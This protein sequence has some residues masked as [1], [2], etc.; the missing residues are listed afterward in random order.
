MKKLAQRRVPKMFFDYADSGDWTES[1]YAAN[2]S[3]FSQIKLRQRVMVDMTNRTLETKM[4]GKKVSM[5]V[6]LA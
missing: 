6:A 1:T 4:I 3:D 5:P 2:E